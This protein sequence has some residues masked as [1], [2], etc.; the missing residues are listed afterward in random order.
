MEK[1]NFLM[2]LTSACTYFRLASINILAAL[3][4]TTIRWSILITIMFYTLLWLRKTF[5]FFIWLYLALFP[6][7][8]AFIF[9]LKVWWSKKLKLWRLFNSL[10]FFL[11]KKFLNFRYN[12]VVI[13]KIFT[14][15]INQLLNK[16]FIPQVAEI[17]K[18][19]IRRIPYSSS[20]RL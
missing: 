18:A 19:I 14:F 4:T 3:I 13:W 10:A 11:I 12:L 15:D 1:D 17:N 7:L 9:Y 8:W 16:A 2:F 20:Y 6:N 5:T